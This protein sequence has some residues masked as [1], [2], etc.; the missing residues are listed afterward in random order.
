MLRYT[1]NLRSAA[2]ATWLGTALG[3]CGGSGGGG[4]GPNANEFVLVVTTLAD[5]GPGSLRA[6]VND[7]TLAPGGFEIVVRFDP[8]LAGGTVHLD[9]PVVPLLD[10]AID[11]SG[12]GGAPGERVTVS[13]D[14]ATHLFEVHLGF[15]VTLRHLVLRDGYSAANGGAVLVEGTLRLEDSV[16]HDNVA[17]LGG[18]AVHCDGG[19]VRILRCAFT[20][21]EAHWG[22]AVMV[23]EAF[24][25]AQESSFTFNHATVSGG[26]AL[27]LIDSDST[28]VN[29]TVHGN[30]A[31]SATFA[32]AAAIFAGL[33][34]GQ[35]GSSL[36]LAHC[37][38]TGNSS[39]AATGPAVNVERELGESSNIYVW[40]TII[41]ENTGPLN[42]DFD[43]HSGDGGGSANITDSVIGV[44]NASTIVW[45]GVNDS[46]VGTL[47]VPADPVLS[48]L[49]PLFGPG[50][51]RVHRFP[52]AGSPA[53][54]RVAMGA[55][56]L[57]GA[58]IDHDQRGLVR[59]ADG[60]TD[61]GAIDVEA[62]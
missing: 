26:G 22:G 15:D 51:G 56:Y 50:D 16:L 5:A 36:L 42:G 29:C 37:T 13:G 53:L 33:N 12:P 30:T 54:D 8:S 3:G 9:T 18:G 25:L 21:N 43:Y 1:V 57:S 58:L 23:A 14:D 52:L 17:D 55:F 44:G 2:L 39:A 4:P 60:F 49:T 46:V 40:G 31:S 6:V 20:G 19:Q 41:A 38:I 34:P 35:G 62:P 59:G 7:A 11:G 10:L 61:A 24:L 32:V 48:V 27:W 47:A 45:D 28:L